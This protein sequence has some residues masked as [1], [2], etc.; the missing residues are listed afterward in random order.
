MGRGNPPHCYTNDMGG[1]ASKRP[2]PSYE[3][4]K[5]RDPEIA[6]MQRAAAEQGADSRPE[7]HQAE[8]RYQHGGAADV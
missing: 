4:G 8:R 2:R 5:V 7:D 6:K 1:S 3:D